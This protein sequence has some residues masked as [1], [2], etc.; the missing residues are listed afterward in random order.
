MNLW[1]VSLHV[2]CQLS[3]WTVFNFTPELWV[4][5]CISSLLG[6]YFV[7]T[8]PV[9]SFFFP[10]SNRLFHR[11]KFLILMRLLYQ[12][13]LSRIML[14]TWTLSQRF[15]YMLSQ[16]F[17]S[18]IVTFKAM[19]YFGFQGVRLM[20]RFFILP[21]GGQLFPQHSL[22]RY[23]SFAELF[24]HRCQKFI[25]CVSADRSFKTNFFLMTRSECVL[26]S[27]L[28]PFSMNRTTH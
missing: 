18:F 8:L 28:L 1:A 7:N 16:K 6:M 15:S 12:L 25:G 26:P 3:N 27:K 21:R 23:L 17:Y 2:F 13:F 10:S 9:C 22:K 20:L 24:M 11:A 19:A 4:F 14:S 5:F